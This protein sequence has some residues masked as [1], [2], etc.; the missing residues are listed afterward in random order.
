MTDAQRELAAA[1]LPALVLINAAV[2]ALGRGTGAIHAL[3]AELAQASERVGP[4]FQAAVADAE[5]LLDVHL[6]LYG[7]DC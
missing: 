5:R 2:N 4:D 6:Q 1:N 7:P 3:R